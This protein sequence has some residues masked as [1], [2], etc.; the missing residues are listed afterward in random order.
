MLPTFCSFGFAAPFWRLIS[1]LINA[2]TGGLPTSTSKLLEDASTFTLTGTFIPE[3]P[4]V[5]SL[6]VLTTWL[7]F[8][9][10]GPKAGP[11]GAPALAL[12][13]STKTEI[14]GIKITSFF[15]S[16]LPQI[17]LLDYPYVLRTN[18]NRNFYCCFKQLNRYLF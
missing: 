9:P 15:F 13:P 4:F 3:K 6:M 11:N 10:N 14:S 7:M 17:L 16:Y 1:F 5:L 18:C 2:L 8:T 12:P